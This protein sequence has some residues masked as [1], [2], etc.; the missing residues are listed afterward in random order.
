M[1]ATDDHAMW[2]C[3]HGIA[4]KQVTPAIWLRQVAS[5]HLRPT[6]KMLSG[7]SQ[8][9]LDALF[10]PSSTEGRMGHDGDR[11]MV[12]KVLQAVVD[13]V[14][15]KKHEWQ[16]GERVENTVRVRRIRCKTDVT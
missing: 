1:H 10:E 14:V 2:I 4:Q 16:V 13:E 15:R 7:A 5:R 11:F 12:T 3:L 8:H 6:P 9:T